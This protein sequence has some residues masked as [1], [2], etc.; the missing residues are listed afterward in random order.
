[1]PENSETPKIANISH[2]IIRMKREL[3]IPFMD[4]IREL[5]TILMDLLWDISL[6][7]LIALRSLIDLNTLILESVK[8]SS[9]IEIMTI[10]KSS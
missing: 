6:S 8:N 10:K 1:M 4:L 2:I 5:I 3:T 7:G 9:V